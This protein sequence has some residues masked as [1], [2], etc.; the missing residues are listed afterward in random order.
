LGCLVHPGAAVVGILRARARPQCR[1]NESAQVALFHAARTGG[2]PNG[3][4]LSTQM[5]REPRGAGLAHLFGRG[6]A[7]FS[8]DFCAVFARF[9]RALP[10]SAPICCGFFAHYSQWKRLIVGFAPAILGENRRNDRQ[11]GRTT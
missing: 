5:R 7:R 4:A 9:L 2:S 6:L 8:R 1:G 10:P 3:A 11:G